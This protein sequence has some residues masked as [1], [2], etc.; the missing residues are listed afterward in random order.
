M[1]RLFLLLICVLCGIVS[2][3]Q[4]TSRPSWVDGY[5]KELDNSY[6][7]VVSASYYD[8]QGAIDRAAQQLVARRSLAT[9][10]EATVSVSDGSISVKGSHGLIASSRILDQFVEHNSNG[11]TVYL[12]AQTLKNP[13]FKYE[14]VSVTESY[15]ASYKAFVPGMAQFEKGQKIK[16]SLFIIGEIAL[17]GGALGC[18]SMKTDYENKISNTK[19][20]SLKQSYSDKANS[21]KNGANICIVG[22]VGLY[23]WN[24]IDGLLA[25]G[26]R[27]VEVGRVAMNFNPYYDMQS[28]GLALNITF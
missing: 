2:A 26:P 12:L 7:E 8:L 24:I 28:T 15:S 5:F 4:N 21:Y 11:Y 27:H 14:S 18:N 22:A 19:D 20:I 23:A 16:G 9:G 6:I 3:A 25:K 1:N 10:Q 13:T 17:I